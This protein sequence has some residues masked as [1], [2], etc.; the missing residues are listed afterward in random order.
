MNTGQPLFDQPIRINS[1]VR[2]ED[3]S[4]LSRLAQEILVLFLRERTVTTSQL[5]QI[6]A[7]YNA[8]LYEVRRHLI[9]LGWRIDRVGGR[10]GQNT[11]KLV[12]LDES[13]FYAKNKHKF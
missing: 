1:S 2:P 12:P 13:E 5:M 10:G 11:C 9:P 4:R 7:Q 6:A 3:E 8:R